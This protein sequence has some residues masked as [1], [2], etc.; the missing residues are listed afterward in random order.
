MSLTLAIA[1]VLS[2]VLT[3]CSSGTKKEEPSGVQTPQQATDS[4]PKGTL[5]YY[6]VDK[7]TTFDPVMVTD[8]STNQIITNVFAGLVGF[9]EKGEV[10]LDLAKGYTV[11]DDG[12][13]Y[14]FTLKD[15]QFSD[16]TPVT[17]ADFKRSILRAVNPDIASPTGESYLNDIAGVAKYIAAKSEL[18]TQLKDK[19]ITD[20]DFKSKVN[21]AFDALKNDPSIT[22]KDDKTLVMVIDAPKPFFLAKLTYPTAFVVGKAYADNAPM[23]AAPANVQKMIGAGGFVMSSYEEGSKVTLKANPSYAGDKAKVA[24]IEMP[25]ITSPQ[26]QLAAY[27]AGDIDIAPVPPG[28]Y[29]TI[30]NDPELGKSLVEFATARI[31]YLA[32]NQVKFEAARDV[33]F[34]LAVAHAIDKEK[35]VQVVYSGTHF[36]AYGVLPDSIAGANGA[37]I[38]KVGYDVA[39]AKEYLKKSGKEGITFTF[40]YRAGDEVTERLAQFVQSQLQ[41]NLGITV[42]LQ[43]MEWGALLTASRNKTELEAF[44]LGWSADYMDP[45]N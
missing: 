34:R 30:K 8:V 4:G 17:A 19:K 22:V 43:P 12:L 10:I 2:L 29:P 26:A 36:P 41:T 45:Q 35:M 1:L 15:A 40:T 27:R 44:Y 7:P 11:S 16:G 28:D 39:K 31:N 42:K 14:T 38:Q 25:V 21:A 20:A 18:N 37:K 24:T 33:N 6:L 32:L 3:A 23:G 5:K 13:T 9:N